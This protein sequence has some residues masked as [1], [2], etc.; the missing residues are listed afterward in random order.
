MMRILLDTNIVLDVLLDRQPFVDDSRRV[1]DAADQGAF[2]ACVAG[3]TLPTIHYICKRHAGRAAADD[4][5]DTC[6]AAFEI[7][8]L[9]RECLVAARRFSGNDFEDNLQLAS[10]VSDF[11]QGIVTRNPQ[12]FPGSPI[13]VYSPAELLAILRV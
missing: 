7:A 12:D 9:Y 6:L 4:A 3:F 2:E 8:A 11:I 10:A 1:W 13:P 5:V